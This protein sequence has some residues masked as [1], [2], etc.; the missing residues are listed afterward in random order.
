[1]YFPR[2][3]KLDVQS[4]RIPRD[5]NFY[6]NSIFIF[7]SFLSPCPK[8]GRAVQRAGRGV[9][10]FSREA[11]DGRR[12]A[13][14]VPLKERRGGGREKKERGGKGVGGRRRGG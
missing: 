1:M 12:Q 10:K 14:A 6:S 4:N 7:S 11:K 5:S 9:Y 13:V 3:S 2:K 8:G